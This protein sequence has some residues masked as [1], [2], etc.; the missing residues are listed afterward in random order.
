MA[1]KLGSGKIIYNALI[2]IAEDRLGGKA[3]KNLGH[4]VPEHVSLT[5]LGH[6]NVP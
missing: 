4:I 1:K 2:P 6:W 5:C 3:R